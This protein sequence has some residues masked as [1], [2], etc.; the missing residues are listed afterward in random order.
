LAHEIKT[1]MVQA[2]L[3]KQLSLRI[4]INLSRSLVGIACL[5][6]ERSQGSIHRLLY[7][8][9]NLYMGESNIKLTGLQINLYLEQP[10]E[11]QLFA[12]FFQRRNQWRLVG[13]IV[14]EAKLNKH[15]NNKYTIIIIFLNTLYRVPQN[16]YQYVVK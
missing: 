16:A 14:E 5:R 7:Q 15:S 12:T 10:M 11:I 2:A 1:A 9:S 8:W 13:F 4:R 3:V 6:C